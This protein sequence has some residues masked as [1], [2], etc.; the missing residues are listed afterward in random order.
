MHALVGLALMLAA[1]RLPASTP[2]QDPPAVAIA[3]KPIDPALETLGRMVGGTW[4]TTGA[5]VAEFKY[6]WRVPGKAIRA[7]GVIAKGTKDEIAAEALY[8]WDA[9]AK[10]VY[11]L[12]FHGHDTIYK[13]LVEMKDGKFTGEFGGLVGDKGVYRFEDKLVDDDTLAAAMFARDKEGKWVKIHS[14]TFKRI[15]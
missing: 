14:F 4:R 5:F 2:A 1:S 11:Y 12:D 13:G 6:E 3:V 9:E 7:V 8:G 15:K 10:R